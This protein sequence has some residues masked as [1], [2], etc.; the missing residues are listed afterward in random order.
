MQSV[1]VR[2]TFRS[3]GYSDQEIATLKNDL[4]EVAALQVRRQS[5]PEA[6]DAFEMTVVVQFV[7]TAILGG[8]IWDGIKI[9]GRSFWNL[10]RSKQSK[11]S[12][13]FPEIDVFEFRFDD[14]DIR[15]CGSDFEHDGQSN[16]LSEQA[17]QFLPELIDCVK[18][19]LESEPLHSI[20]KLV[21]DVYDPK[22]TVDDTG[23]PHFTFL[24]PWRVVGIDVT[25]PLSYFAEDRRMEDEY[26][27]I[28]E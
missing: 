6:G 1:A 17:F 19:H 27:P 11:H 28:Q 26:I 16:Y 2:C 10:Y 3:R 7:G 24:Y 20:D 18:Q 22:I 15:I 9:L 5:Y 8:I 4:S 21:V 23:L 14:I 13:C 12:N 25:S